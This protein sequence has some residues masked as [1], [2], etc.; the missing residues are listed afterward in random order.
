MLREQYDPGP[1]VVGAGLALG[2]GGGYAINPAAAPTTLG[3]TNQSFFGKLEMGRERMRGSQAGYASG[4]L[5]SDDRLQQGAG[6]SFG[7]RGLSPWRSDC[8][9]KVI[10]FVSEKSL[11]QVQQTLHKYDAQDVEIGGYSTFTYQQPG[12]GVGL[13]SVN[14]DT[15]YYWFHNW[16]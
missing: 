8:K 2:I 14:A 3:H 13:I 9:S 11:R 5:F 7:Q 4:A 1:R 12:A 15:G 16:L 10:R 6:R